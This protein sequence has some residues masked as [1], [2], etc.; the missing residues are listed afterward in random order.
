MPVNETESVCYAQPKNARDRLA[1]ANDFVK[2]FEWTVPLVV[3]TLAND[4]TTNA[5]EAAYAGW[6]ERLYVIGADGT[7]AYKGAMG[8]DGF[9]PDEV[10]AWLAAHPLPAP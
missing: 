8:P 1:I 6:P 10:A 4:R 3:D 9:A 2:R 5:A 7:I